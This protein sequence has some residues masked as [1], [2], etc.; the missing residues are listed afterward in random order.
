MVNVYSILFAATPFIGT[1]GGS[2]ILKKKVQNG[3]QLLA[4]KGII[5]KSKS[6]GQVREELKK[7][8]IKY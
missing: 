1:L 8:N 2:Y 3:K 4:K 5:V 7:Q 6:W